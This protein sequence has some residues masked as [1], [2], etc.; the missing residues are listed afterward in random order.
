MTNTPEACRTSIDNSTVYA[1]VLYNSALSYMTVGSV[2]DD[3]VS[4]SN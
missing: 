1:G 3:E 4:G 2:Y